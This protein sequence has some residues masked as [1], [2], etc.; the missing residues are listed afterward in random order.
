MSGQRTSGAY[1]SNNFNTVSRSAEGRPKQGARDPG[2]FVAAEFTGVRGAR[3]KTLTDRLAISRPASSATA[4]RRAMATVGS[5]LGRG[6]RKPAFAEFNHAAQ[7][8]NRLAAQHDRGMRF[9][10]GLRVGPGRAELHH[11]PVKGRFFLGPERLH[12][13]HPFAQQLEPGFILGTVIVHFLNI[14]AAAN[15]KNK[16]PVGHHV[17]TCDRFCGDDG[18]ALRDQANAGAPASNSS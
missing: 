3:G 18:V 13:Q 5:N 7:R 4:F 17:Q 2:V 12:G 8:V 11:L 15:A 14:P 9:L 1:S 16:P 6:S 10:C